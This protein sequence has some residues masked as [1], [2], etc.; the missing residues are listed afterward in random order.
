MPRN[1]LLHIGLRISV[2]DVKNHGKNVADKHEN[3]Q[4]ST[5]DGLTACE[6]FCPL[7]DLMHEGAS[8]LGLRSLLFISCPVVPS[9]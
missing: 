5:S 1:A 3:H 8:V 6:A 4:H 2:G 7:L 9:I